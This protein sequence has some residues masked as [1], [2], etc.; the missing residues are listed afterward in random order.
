MTLCWGCGLLSVYYFI[1]VSIILF[2]Y[3]L[4]KFRKTICH[5]HK[6]EGIGQAYAPFIES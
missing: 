5:L 2:V 6:L 3:G 4:N 1:I